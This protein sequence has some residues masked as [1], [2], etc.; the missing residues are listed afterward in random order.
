MKANVNV[1]ASDVFTPEQLAEH[2]RIREAAKADLPEI[3]AQVEAM[4]EVEMREGVVP[5]RAI[6]ILRY[7]RKRLGLSD[8]DMTA[9]SGLDAAALETMVGPDANPSLEIL[10]AYATAVGKRVRILLDDENSPEAI[11]ADQ[12]EQHRQELLA[13]KRER[14]ARA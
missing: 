12:R 14:E 5:W 1:K 11:E 2:A 4:Q 9:T 13:R 8:D 10:K 6:A 3:R 7:E